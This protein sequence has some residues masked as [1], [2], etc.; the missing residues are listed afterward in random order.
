MAASIAVLESEWSRKAAAAAMTVDLSPA[1]L[2]VL[3]EGL[4]FWKT[5]V[6]FTKGLPYAEK[7]AKIVAAEALEQKLKSALPPR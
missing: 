2:A 7:T 6:A 1:E 5:K 3:I 4:D